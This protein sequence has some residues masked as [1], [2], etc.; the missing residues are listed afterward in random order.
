[1]RFF[2]AHFPDPINLR[3]LC[4]GAV[5][6]LHSHPAEKEDDNDDDDDALLPLTTAEALWLNGG[7]GSGSVPKKKK[8]SKTRAPP[9]LLAPGVKK[10]FT[11]T[12]S[13]A[14]RMVH[15]REVLTNP[16]FTGLLEDLLGRFHLVFPP[17]SSMRTAAL[18]MSESSVFTAILRSIHRHHTVPTK[19]LQALRPL[20]LQAVATSTTP[21][22]SSTLPPTTVMLR[23]LWKAHPD[24]RE[25]LDLV[26]DTYITQAMREHPEWRLV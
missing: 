7:S 5:L 15:L 23:G 12:F 9:P 25:A 22:S 13:R 18:R 10:W 11:G 3:L 24:R 16:F 2:S 19:D 17:D 4:K 20:L 1:M 14:L 21:P 6:L 26:L 8:K